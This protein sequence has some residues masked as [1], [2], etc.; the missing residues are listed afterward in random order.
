MATNINS[1]T[2][3]TGLNQLA[4]ED[5]KF[6]IRT[7]IERLLPEL[8]LY[9]DA[10]K[11]KLPKNQGRTVNWRKFNS[12]PAVTTPLTEG[13]TPD[14]RDLDVT[15]IEALLAQYGDYVVTSDLL[16]T[17]GIDPVVTEASE[18][19]GE[20]AALSVELALASKLFSGTNVMFAG[21][22]SARTALT[23]NDKITGSDV[24][25]L[26]RQLKKANARKFSDG[27]YHAI[28]D[29][30]MTFDLTNDSAWQ[31]VAKYATPDQMLKGEIGKMHG[32][33]F[34]EATAFESVAGTSNLEV[35]RA[36]FYGKNSYGA[37]DLENGGG[38]PDIIVKQLGSAGTDDPLNQRGSVGWKLPF[39]CEIL[40]PTALISY[41][42][43][44]TE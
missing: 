41:E 18:L 15:Q 32:F 3:G 10:M 36:L 43:A 22:K 37:V 4:P 33:R 30:D 34:M 19:C 21:G 42:C 12:L 2:Q 6:Y 16:Q 11:K 39:T 44:V 27:Y 35:H 23:A 8:F 20:Q 24:K 31:D 29:P 13:K 26:R 40:Q 7:L 5:K 1:M 17:T 25:K 38:K 9:N 28:I 14:G